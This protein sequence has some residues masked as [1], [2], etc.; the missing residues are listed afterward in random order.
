MRALA[1]LVAAGLGVGLPVPGY[2]ESF[3]G[4]ERIATGDLNAAEREIAEQRRVF[5]NDPDLLINLAHVYAR[6]ERTAEAQDLYRAVLGRPDEEM[7]LP[8]GRTMMA[9]ALASEALRR[10]SAPVIATR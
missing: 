4:A 1:I 2:A 10:I 7:I 6:T 3:S 8:D 9:H 5:P